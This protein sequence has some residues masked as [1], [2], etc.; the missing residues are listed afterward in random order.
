MAVCFDTAG[1][2]RRLTTILLSLAVLCSLP[3]N[4]RASATTPYV[5]ITQ[6]ITKTG[7]ANVENASANQILQAFAAVIVT[8]KSRDFA[9]YVA[10]AVE[11]RHDL[12]Y[13]I[14][15]TA[16]TILKLNT[17][18]KDNLLKWAN[19]IVV[20]AIL[21][22]PYDADPIIRAALFVLPQVKDSIVAAA[23]KAAPDQE[24][25]ILRAAGEAQTMAFLDQNPFAS[26]NPRNYGGAE[27]VT[28]PEQ[29]PGP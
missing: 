18:K 3:E 22:D 13:K 2:G 7:A 25:L 16:L 15:E 28:S 29:P 19:E 4:T 8:K 23:T 10:A 1:F 11:L 12:A 17:S 5:E 14:V 21:A 26:I 9:T 6:A 27:P 24:F 20:A